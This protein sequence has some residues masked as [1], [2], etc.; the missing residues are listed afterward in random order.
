MY[1]RQTWHHATSLLN[2]G[3]A[4][5]HAGQIAEA[6]GL[7]E[8]AQAI[9]EAL[10]DRHFFAR[11]LIQIGYAELVTSGP[12]TAAPAIARAMEIVAEIGDIWGIAEGLEAVAT[13]RSLSQPRSTVLL[14]AAA[15]RLRE[16]ISMHQHPADAV[17]NRL[18]LDRARDLITAATFAETWQQGRALTLSEAV[19]EAKR[20]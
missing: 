4:Q 14:A 6:T 11:T 19:A 18:F 12:V 7:L 3:T 17:L 8:R 15:A 9:Y 5:M 2:L 16:R 1:K 20:I 10:G 13:V